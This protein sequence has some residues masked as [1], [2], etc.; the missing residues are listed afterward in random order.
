MTRLKEHGVLVHA[1]FGNKITATI[2]ISSLRDV[3]CINGVRRISLAQ[4]VTSTNDNARDM[5]GMWAIEKDE[6]T[7][8]QGESLTGKG[9]IVGVIDTGIDYNHINFKDKAGKSRVKRVY[10]PWEEDGNNP[11]VG[12]NPLPGR[13]YTT[14]QEIAALTADNDITSHGTHTTGTAAGGYTANNM[15]G[16]APEADLV[17]CGMPEDKFT[18]ANIANALAYIFDYAD[19]EGKPAVVNM[20][21]GSNDGAHD[22]TSDLCKVFEDLSDK[23]RIC[24]V[25]AGNDGNK[26]IHTR[27]EMTPSDTIR[28]L[29]RNPNGNYYSGYVSM[30]S[31]D[32]VKHDVYFTIVNSSTK[33][34]LYRSSTFRDLDPEEVVEISNENDEDFAKYMTGTVYVAMALEDNG[35]F[36]SIVM[37][38]ATPAVNTYYIVVHYGVSKATT[39]E[40]WCDS[41]TYLTQTGFGEY[42]LGDSDGSISDLATGTGTISVGAYTSKTE[43]EQERGTAQYNRSALGDI[44]YF[45]SY[46]PDCN[47]I[48]RPEVCAPGY[49]VVSSY[50]R[51]DTKSRNN[52]KGYAFITTVDD[53]DYPYGV[54]YGTSMST[55]VVAGAIA[56]WLQIDPTLNVDDIKRVIAASSTKDDYVTDVNK[57]GAGKLNVSQ[58][59]AYLLESSSDPS[60]VD[61]I[62]NNEVNV[63]PNPCDGTFVV[64]GT[65]IDPYTV[66]VYSLTGTLVHREEVR[67]GTKMITLG[68]FVQNGV[69]VV[70]IVDCNGNK[71]IRKMIVTK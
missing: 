38:V 3:I 10:Q 42:V 58:G 46:G 52:G 16:I 70:Q 68:E 21:I 67:R 69:Y 41:N 4:Q 64:S 50:S 33:Q 15:H 47:G 37:P 18:D 61:N 49:V 28:S 60:V 13:D 2:P 44:A 59:A 45:S 30:W 43:V 5:S 26:Y 36:H 51:Y 7:C 32:E 62:I 12:G 1:R 65:E 29:L 55:P 48:V 17:L 34:E 11:M 23:G 19:K 35:K 8:S 31:K 27:K 20:S 66:Y 40:A 14:E 71:Q 6:V 54:I 56:L 39:L 9:V 57:W 24:V 63:Y 53:V 25:S 22:G